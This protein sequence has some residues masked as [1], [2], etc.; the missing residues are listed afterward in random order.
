[1]TTQPADGIEERAERF[2]YF[3]VRVQRSAAAA[4]E[5]DG[6]IAGLVERLGTGEKERFASGEELL[7]LVD[8]W[9]AVRR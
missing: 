6:P 2:A 9:S 7:R 3:M 8:Q 1:M 4:G 5:T